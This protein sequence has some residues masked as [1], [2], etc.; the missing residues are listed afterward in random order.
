MSEWPGSMNTNSMSEWPGSMNSNYSL[1]SFD[2]L[3][4][5]VRM[6]LG[7]SIVSSCYQCIACIVFIL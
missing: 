5:F 3:L 2:D 6:K 7:K 4:N 1:E